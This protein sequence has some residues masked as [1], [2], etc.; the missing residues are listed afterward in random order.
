MTGSGS[1]QILVTGGAGFIGSHL[2]DRLLWR[3]D[4]VTVID[5][6]NEFY[7]P[8]VK[9]D[10]VASDTQNPKFRLEHG[11]IRNIYDV[12]K[13]FAGADYDA[14]VHL[15]AMAGVRPSLK[16]P[17][18]YLDVNVIGTQRILDEI[19]KAK[20]KPLF[21]FGSSS[22]VY[23][24]RPDEM[25]KETDRVDRPLSPYA[26]SKA[27]G[28]EI[29]FAAHHT[30]GLQVVALRF[31]T[32]FGPR[33][34]PDLAIHKF[35]DLIYN[36]KPIEI[37][38][39]GTSKRDYTFVK[40]IVY[41]V[42]KAT[43]LKSPGFEIINLGRSEPVVLSHVITC[44]ENSLGKKATIEYKSPQIGDVPNTFACIDKAREMLGYAPS[45]SIEKG[46]D[47]FVQWYL[48]RKAKQK[49]TSA[50]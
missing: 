46:I 21:V 14:V 26:A 15:A 31:F 25:F 17:A 44:L 38:G 24:E 30:K 23:G 27:A 4:R 7:D 47:E 37:Y 33:Q 32:V 48:A 5:N 3:G 13:I 11:D 2:V 29:C 28:E 16:D 40:D 1:R 36:D 10:N 45:T 22:S 19:T 39:D 49:S 20:R 50:V 41:G 35:C 12:Q 43:E 6:F 18:L 9:W 8:A 34:R 42:E